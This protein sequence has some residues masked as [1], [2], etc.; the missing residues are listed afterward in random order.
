MTIKRIYLAGTLTAVALATGCSKAPTVSYANDVMPVL[1]LHCSE[2]H[3]AGGAGTEK[4]GFAVDSYDSVMSG[5]RLGPMVVPGD[6]L[7]SNLYRMVAGEVD[8]SIRM[9][10]QKTALSADE[11]AVIQTWIAEGALDN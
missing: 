1:N 9:P 10:H 3:V 7:S 5:T 8:E 2:C 11:V 4:S 6:P